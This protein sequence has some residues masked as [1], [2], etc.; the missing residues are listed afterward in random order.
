MYP[1]RASVMSKKIF[2]DLSE[3]SKLMKLRTMMSLLLN[4][5]G[6]TLQENRWSIGGCIEKVISEE[7]N[8][9]GYTVTEYPNSKKIDIS[10]NSF[11]LSIKYSS[12]S[13]IKLH[14]SLNSTNS[15]TTFTDLLLITPDY[16]YLLTSYTLQTHGVKISE[17]LQS[18]GDG[19]VMK[20]KML[21]QLHKG[22]KDKFKYM[23][24][25]HL[26]IGKCKH[27][28]TINEFYK[29]QR[30]KCNKFLGRKVF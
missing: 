16:M 23:I 30:L 4:E 1:K 9:L 6:T 8:D 18:V 7:L 2:K 14:N 11:P 21:T 3:K 12:G 25:L 10:I 24:P 15:D 5:Y 28:P 26:Q 17:Y 19:L 20:R 27:K 29:S 13:S 22:K